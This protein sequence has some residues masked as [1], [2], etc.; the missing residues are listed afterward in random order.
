MNPKPHF[1]LLASFRFA[2]AGLWDVL[3]T[4]RNFRIHLGVAV[5]VIAMGLWLGVS[6]QE[7]IGLLLCIG[8]VL[9]AEIF[10]TGAELLV[11]LASPTYHPLAK[12]VKDLAAGAV[13]LAAIIAVIVGLLLLGPP[14]LQRLG[15]LH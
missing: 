15:L 10:N 11:D 4:E 5:A 14:L 8:F 3:R 1:S 9:L 6:R 12:R 13:L 7:W 2:G